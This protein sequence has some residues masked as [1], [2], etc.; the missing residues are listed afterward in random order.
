M[1]NY[2]KPIFPLIL[3]L[4]FSMPLTLCIAKEYSDN[5]TGN[6]IVRPEPEQLGFLFM[7]KESRDLL[8]QRRSE[9][10]DKQYQKRNEE[11]QPT[12]QLN[13]EP[14]VLEVHGLVLR[15]GGKPTV[16]LNNSNTFSGQNLSDNI[17]I[18]LDYIKRYNYQI[19]VLLDNKK[20]ILKP[21]Q[22]W[23]EKENRIMEAY[24][25]LKEE[26]IPTKE[27]PPEQ[28]IEE[29]DKQMLEALAKKYQIKLSK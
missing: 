19:P 28:V 9:F 7:S 20:I 4:V 27:T 26:K 21:G 1:N 13:S 14:V 23:N 11:I 24:D 12:L 6:R 10:N 16:W 2:K 29:K 8:N 18:E 5:D 3:L 25:Y 22:I 17:S 15:S